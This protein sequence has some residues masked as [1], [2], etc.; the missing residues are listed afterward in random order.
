MKRLDVSDVNERFTKNPILGRIKLFLMI[1]VSPL[2]FIA[3]SWEEHGEDY[4]GEMKEGLK[5]VFLPWETP[6][7]GGKHE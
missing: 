6:Y 3:K 2:L 1:L 4:L 7:K 5:V